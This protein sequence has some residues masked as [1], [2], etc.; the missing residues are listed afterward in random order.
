MREFQLEN[1]K[2]RERDILIDCSSIMH[3]YKNAPEKL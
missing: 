3:Q 1:L 2:R